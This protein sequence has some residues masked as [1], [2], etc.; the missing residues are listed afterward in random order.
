M[1][2]THWGLSGPAIIRLS[3]WAAR[4]LQASSY[5]AILR[6]KFMPDNTEE[7]IRDDLRLHFEKN[8][9]KKCVNANFSIFP[10]RYWEQLLNYLSIS[11]DKIGS[12]LAKKE[13]N[14]LVQQI[15][16]AE[17]QIEGKGV[18]KEEFVTCGGVSL[19][20]VNCKEMSSKIVPNLYFTGEL[21]D[22]D[23]I[24]GGF[25]FQNA[26]TSAYLVAQSI[27]KSYITSKSNS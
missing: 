20:E 18:F 4:E 10:K 13:I 12:Q 5:K 21:L 6:I 25:N 16:N 17:F 23:G 27:A 19:K 14:K 8:A 15:A 3:A 1:L 11:S 9:S 24:T 26:W 7:E 2:I 22:I